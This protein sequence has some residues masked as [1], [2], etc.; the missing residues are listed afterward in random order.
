MNSIL[1][2]SGAKDR[3]PQ[4]ERNVSLR[5]RYLVGEQKGIGLGSFHRTKKSKSSST[6][7]GASEMTIPMYGVGLNLTKVVFFP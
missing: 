4:Q 7:S 5:E 6:G 1:R 2:S 3:V